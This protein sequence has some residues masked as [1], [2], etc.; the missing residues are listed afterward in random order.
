MQAGMPGSAHLV[1]TCAWPAW[2]HHCTWH[3]WTEPVPDKCT[4]MTSRPSPPAQIS[5]AGP[6]SRCAL[7]RGAAASAASACSQE[8]GR[9]AYIACSKWLHNGLSCARLISGGGL[10]SFGAATSQLTCSGRPPESGTE[11][12]HRCW[13]SV[14]SGNFRATH[15]PLTCSAR[16]PQ[17]GG[18]YQQTRHI[19]GNFVVA[20]PQ[21]AGA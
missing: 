16:A 10:P 17:T 2:Q 7:Q 6:K 15:Q 19:G 13:L 9:V 8:G 1:H 20:Y 18:L 4:H 14:L 5:V 11:S 12:H 3:L 21:R